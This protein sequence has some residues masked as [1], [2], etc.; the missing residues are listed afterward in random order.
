MDVSRRKE[1]KMDPLDE[2]LQEYLS[3]MT[4]KEEKAYHIAKSHL[5]CSFDLKKSVGFLDFVK[6]IQ[7]KV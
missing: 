4:E 1:T 3:K 2:L 7:S 6:Q 5:M